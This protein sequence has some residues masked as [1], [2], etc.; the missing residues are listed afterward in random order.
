MASS[1]RLA[2]AKPI[3]GTEKADGV[4]CNMK[5]MAMFTAPTWH[6]LAALS[7]DLS[8]LWSNV[9][10]FFFLYALNKFKCKSKNV[11][12]WKASA[13]QIEDEHMDI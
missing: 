8:E 5:E 7:F 9:F 13:R 2:S 1:L 6:V 11:L 10:G 12:N 3:T 4:H